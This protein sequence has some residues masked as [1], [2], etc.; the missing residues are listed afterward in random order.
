MFSLERVSGYS[1]AG[2]ILN[3]Y[4]RPLLEIILSTI[5]IQTI[6]T[7]TPARHQQN[8]KFMQIDPLHDDTR[9]SSSEIEQS[10]QLIPLL[11]SSQKCWSFLS[12]CSPGQE[13]VARTRVKQVSI[14]MYFLY[15]QPPS[16]DGTELRQK[17]GKQGTGCWFG[18]P[19][20]YDDSNFQDI[21]ELCKLFH[22]TIFISLFPNK[23][24]SLHFKV[25]PPPRN[26]FKLSFS[27]LQ[28]FR[29][30]Q[31]GTVNSSVH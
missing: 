6:I 21:S 10:P 12:W 27:N 13:R 9:S 7:N 3:D 28:N 4:L 25:D 8:N 1:W 29:K 24:I 30:M 26:L 14:I 11:S 31:A 5:T 23:W 20:I 2:N 18:S 19:P 17:I 22:L 16:W 15:L